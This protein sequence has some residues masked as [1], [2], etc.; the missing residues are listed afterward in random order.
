MKCNRICVITGTRAEYGLLRPLLFRLRDN[1]KVELSLVVTGTHLMEAFGNTQQEIREDGFTNYEKVEIPLMEDSKKAMVN[2]TGV[3][4]SG[5]GEVYEK[6]KPELVVVLGDRYEI[7][8]AAI[9]AHFMG[10]PIA[11]LCGGDVTEGA[12]DDA[13]RHCITK[14]STLHFPGCEQSAN[15]IIQMG[16]SPERVYN[17]GEPGIENCLHA[18]LM[19]REELSDNL[20]FPAM[21]RAYAV[22]TFHPVTMEENTAKGQV[23][24][25][26][27]AMDEQK[28]LAYI[29]T[30]ANAD[31]GGRVINEVWQNEGKKRKNWY[32]TPSLGMRRYLS[33]VKYADVVIGNSSSALVEV[34]AL[35]IPSVNIGDRQ[36][37]RMMAQ[38]VISVPAEESE[39]STAIKRARST[40]FHDEMK[41]MELPFGNG[42]TSAQVEKTI[43]EYLGRENRTTEKT[44]YDLEF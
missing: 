41:G 27:H 35:G 8:A 18:E 29:I 6:I 34:P 20:N 26:I 43:L 1:E 25:L 40:Q 19:T 22:V 24:E 31:A 44:F 12:V 30:L 15:R 14:L 21:K 28:N 11:H 39:I 16:E 2:A 13:I 10:I 38:S 7:L 3:A 9:A 32:V 33:A 42:T 23:M 17:V 4:L 5:F 36:K 37:G